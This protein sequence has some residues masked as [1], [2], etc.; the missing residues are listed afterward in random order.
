MKSAITAFDIAKARK[1]FEESHLQEAQ[2][3][4]ITTFA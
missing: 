2:Y 4:M 1:P 3:L